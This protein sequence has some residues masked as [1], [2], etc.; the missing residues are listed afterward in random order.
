[1]HG[2]FYWASLRSAQSTFL[3]LCAGS[4]CDALFADGS[5][6]CGEWA[7]RSCCHGASRWCAAERA[8]HGRVL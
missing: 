6:D 3:Q 7:E 4:A 8:G 1:V 2:S 5:E